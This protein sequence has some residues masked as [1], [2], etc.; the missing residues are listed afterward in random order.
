[1]LNRQRTAAVPTRRAT[2]VP[3]R[4]N[5]SER[6][7]RI[8]HAAV[9]RFTR[10]GA[11]AFTARGVAKEAGVSLGSVQHI[12]PSKNELLKAMLEF[13]LTE[14]EAVFQQFMFD[15]PLDS[16]T[17]L[18]TMIRCLVEDTMQPNTRKFFFNLYA[19]GCH[20]DLAARLLRDIY[21]RHQ[22]RVASVIAAA[23]PNL[24][25]GQCL[26]FALHIISLIDGLTVHT[27]P[28]SKIIGRRDTLPGRVK[29]VV[30]LML[31]PPPHRSLQETR[32]SE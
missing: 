11:A 19:L 17:R 8:L 25:A 12:F 3:R 32:T 29:D 18:I 31:G 22:R 23:R 14:Y 9:N 13:K 5:I 15:L 27:G 10:E 1:M 16:E 7:K 24:S 30:L 28:R 2:A 20:D 26:D 4:R 6:G 21:A